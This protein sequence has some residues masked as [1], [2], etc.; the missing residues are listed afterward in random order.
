MSSFVLSENKICLC[1]LRSVLFT[2]TTNT[3]AIYSII[4]TILKYETDS[5][6]AYRCIEK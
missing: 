5:D 4:Q 3:G 1:N 6:F 2:Y